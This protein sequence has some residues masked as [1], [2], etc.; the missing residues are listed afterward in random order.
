MSALREQLIRWLDERTG[1][2][3]EAPRMWGTCAETVEMQGLLLLEMRAFVLNPLVELRE[4]RRVLD[5]YDAFLQKRFR[6]ADPGPL[7]RL[8]GED[9]EMKGLARELGAFRDALGRQ[10][11]EENPFLHSDVA[12]RLRFGRDRTPT[13]SA[14][15]GYYEEFRKAA[16][17]LTRP[18]D[19]ETGRVRK[20]VETVTDFELN[21]VRVRQSNG[22][23]AEVLLLLQQQHPEQ[24]S[25]EGT[26][27]EDEV[28][29]GLLQL[30]TMMEWARSGESVNAL[31]VDNQLQRTRLAVQAMRLFPSRGITTVE[32]GGNLLGRSKPVELRTQDYARCIEVLSAATEPEPFD[33]VDEI[34]A[35]DLDR[36]AIKLGRGVGQVRC[37]VLPELLDEIREVG[38]RARVYGHRYA[39]LL[40]PAF[41]LAERIEISEPSPTS[42]S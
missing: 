20:D 31:P 32:L 9:P 21:D 26:F 12:V 30:V 39:P 13:A 28:R 40:G 37:Y 15:T 24:R 22:L 16:R 14:F 3:L 17:A 4:P 2:I 36:N 34:R 23:P 35:I 5:T 41:V 10:T 7:C 18:L 6:R 25:V 42:E 33:R 27:P 11:P 19:K 29:A 8:L 1:A 38:V